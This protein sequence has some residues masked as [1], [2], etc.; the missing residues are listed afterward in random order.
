MWTVLSA[1][2]SCRYDILNRL[3][4]SSAHPDVSHDGVSALHFL[5]SWD[6]GQA[7][8]IGHKL[9][10]AGADVNAQ[11]QRGRTFGGTSLMWSVYANHLSHSAILIKLGADPLATTQNG[12]DALSFGAR[13]HL[14]PHLRLLIENIRPSQLRDHIGRLIAAVAG[15]ESRFTRM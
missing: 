15:G 5:S 14:A 8:S 10:L 13:S 11:A 2:E 4:S 7:E 9:I 3:L 1:A 6:L 12:D